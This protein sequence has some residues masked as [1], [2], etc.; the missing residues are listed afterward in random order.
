MPII[1]DWLDRYQPDLLALQETKVVDGDFPLEPLCG[2]GWKVF[3][4]GEKS[5]NGVAMITR[6]SPELVEFGLD[7]GDGGVSGTR[8]AHLRLNGIDVVNT[9]VPQG[10]ALDSEKFA[11]KLEWLA[12]LRKYFDARFLPERDNVLWVGDI[13]VAP[14]PMDVHD[15]KLVWPHVCHC[16]E[17]IDAFAAVVD[18]GFVDIFRKY[19]PDPGTFT[20]WDYR[21]RSA[22][23]RNRGW[24]IDHVLAGAKLAAAATGCAVD[25][26]PRAM[27]RPSDHTFV[28]ADFNQVSD[29]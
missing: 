28:F 21:Q 12:R 9:Y 25:K 8:L 20:F 4:R 3:F 2:K 7:D 14:L 26:E 11:F 27:E 10:Q 6:D 17:V 23:E 13:N 19:L 29:G 22:Y 1:L 16:Q 24:R 18:W 5:Y 15:S